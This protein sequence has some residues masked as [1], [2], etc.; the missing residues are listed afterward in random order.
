MKLA[1]SEICVVYFRF[2]SE[3]H[4]EAEIILNSHR[5]DI[6][7]DV[8]KYDVYQNCMYYNPSPET[9]LSF[10]RDGNLNPNNAVKP[11][12]HTASF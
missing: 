11:M 6:I 5:A 10:L 9:M 2:I 8:V 3:R 1:W 4:H 7:P 12:L